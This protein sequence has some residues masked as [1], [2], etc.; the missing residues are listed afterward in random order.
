MSSLKLY[1]RPWVEFDVQD[2]QHR[3]WYF[4]FVKDN[5]WG[6]IPCRFTV[7]N[8]QGDL[9][10]VIERKLNMFYIEKEFGKISD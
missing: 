5:S 7:S 1:G 2:Q 4:N 6:R 10:S 9:V 3:Q 8:E